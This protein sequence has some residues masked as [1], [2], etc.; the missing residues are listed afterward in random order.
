[1]YKVFSR[2]VLRT[3]LLSFQGLE[4]ILHD[5]EFFLKKLNERQIQEAIFWASPQ[6]ARELK[7]LLN[8]EISDLDEKEQ[9]VNTMVKYLSR[10]STRCTPF[11]LFAGCSVGTLGRETKIDLS[12]EFDYKIRL[13]MQLL[14]SVSLT[15]NKKPII[16]E[17]LRYQVSSS[18]YQLG[19]SYRYI[20][21]CVKDNFHV[22]YK[23]SS[24]EKTDYL[25]II[26]S[27]A[28]KKTLFV[29]LVKSIE[30]E[31]ISMEEAK[32]FILELISN[33]I[34]IS[35]IEPYVC[36]DDYLT[37]VIDVLRPL[38]LKDNLI[39]N[40]LMNINNQLRCSESVNYANLYD[41]TINDFKKNDIQ[42][43][44]LRIFQVDMK[45]INNIA[46]L[47]ES[48]T[49]ELQSTLKLLNKITP[50]EWRNSLEQFQNVFYDRYEEK[51]IPLLLALDAEIGI[52]YPINAK[53]NDIAPLIDNFVL[54]HRSQNNS[55]INRSKLSAILHNKYL[56]YRI[57]GLNELILFDDDFKDFNEIWSDL[58]QTFFSLFQIIQN[59]PNTLLKINSVS[60][61]S[62]ANLITR[63]AYCDSDIRDFIDEITRKEKELTNG[64]IAEIVHLPDSR[65]GNIVSRPHVREYEIVCLTNTDLFDEFQIPL[66][67][68]MISIKSGKLQ[69]HSKKLNKQIVPRLTSAHNYQNDSIAAYLFL[70]DFQ[71]YSIGRSSLYFDWG[72]LEQ[73]IDFKPRVRY[74]NS[75]LSL[76]SWKVSTDELKS[77]FI[78]KCNED[79]IVS[80]K[81]WR[82]MRL[83]PRFT[84]LR[85]GD[86]KLFIDWESIISI[87]TLFSI[88]KNKQSVVFEEF[89]FD[90]DNSV[91]SGIDGAYTNE[92]IVAFYKDNAK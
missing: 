34:L 63:F 57:K 90:K 1:M 52:G 13:D 21:S 80:I 82:K 53:P 8:N 35:E 10:M 77:Y 28:R 24:V 73:D 20:E 70:C 50:I 74:K 30:N 83:I 76:A 67:D 32:A 23:I 15:L 39:T 71:H 41:L 36:G 72:Y 37:K 46:I 92:C 11:G 2:F 47:G 87:T 33:Q 86:S 60:G 40:S 4:E 12:S 55:I 91:V 89:I 31:Y 44:D 56:E 9:L 51:E 59:E 14:Y 18:I 78:D 45:K 17:N 38:E 49:N 7:K 29:E 48:I 79:V 62:A 5:N 43:D 85:E 64:I 25:D 66:S 26:L 54:P 65:S 6:L 68:L 19:N 61:I 42:F 3:P 58:P 16:R 88:I 69:L 75:I 27:K 81:K 22:M 84:L